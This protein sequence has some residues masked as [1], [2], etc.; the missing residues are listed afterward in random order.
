MHN[1]DWEEVPGMDKEHFVDQDL[2]HAV[3]IACMDYAALE[4]A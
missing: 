4:H 2:D 1:L 3:V